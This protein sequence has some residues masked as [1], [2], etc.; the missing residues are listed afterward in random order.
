MTPAAKE[1]IF[2][3]LRHQRTCDKFRDT[4]PDRCPVQY[5]ADEVKTCC[6]RAYADAV[7]MALEGVSL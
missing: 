2:Q 5:V 1:A 4:R 3:A 7:A 6:C